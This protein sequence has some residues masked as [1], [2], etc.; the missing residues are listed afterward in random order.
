M[1]QLEKLTKL[2]KRLKETELDTVLT[3]ITQNEAS[4]HTLA[5]RID[6]IHTLQPDKAQ[7]KELEHEEHVERHAEKHLHHAL[8]K[9]LSTMQDI[10][11]DLQELKIEKLPATPLEELHKRI[12]QI[13]LA[14]ERYAGR[15]GELNRTLQYYFLAK[16]MQLGGLHGD[17]DVEK[18]VTT[19]KEKV[20]KAIEQ[21]KQINTYTKESMETLHHLFNIIESYEPNSITLDFTDYSEDDIII[22]TSFISKVAEALEKREALIVKNKQTV[23][24]PH[25]VI[26]EAKKQSIFTTHK[27]LITKA[28]LNSFIKAFKANIAHIGLHN[29]DEITRLWFKAKKASQTEIHQFLK[30]ADV[31]IL[32]FAL[33]HRNTLILTNDKEIAETIEL[34]K[35]TF[36][37]NSLVLKFEDNKLKKW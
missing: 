17:T 9:L 28:Y 35:D 34:N 10:S 36:G 23:I 13:I 2:R 33:E 3:A 18:Q 30:T 11:K 8:R 27:S 24:I 12:H 19:G 31:H 29:E 16:N 6:T 1:I 32:A 22:D 4:L 25:R 14:E 37:H 15:K 5:A 20:Y 7:Q 21:L 26:E